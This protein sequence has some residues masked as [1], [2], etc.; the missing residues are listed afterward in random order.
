MVRHQPLPFAKW[1]YGSLEQQLP[2]HV[3][4]SINYLYIYVGGTVVLS[5][6]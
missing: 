6:F 4:P 2:E 3:I 1:G 5:P